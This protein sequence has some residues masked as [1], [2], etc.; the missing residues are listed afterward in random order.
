MYQLDPLFG[1]HADALICDDAGQLM[2]GSFYGRSGLIQQML[3]SFHLPTNQ[4]GIDQFTVKQSDNPQEPPRKIYVGDPNRLEKF[5]GRMSRGLFGE[6]V[7]MFVFDP[8]IQQP[9][10]SNRT[11]WLVESEAKTEQERTERFWSL[12]KLLSPVP[13]MEH[14]R[15]VVLERAVKISHGR[16]VGEWP[17][18]SEV[19]FSMGSVNAWQLSLIANFEAVISELVA[20]RVLTLEP[21]VK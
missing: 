9:D 21:A 11:S 5:S 8:R 16:I 20:G 3:A 10:K 6:L 14:W 7:H 19:S 15:D 13:L 2:F 17:H 18:Q 12:V 1:V 4:G